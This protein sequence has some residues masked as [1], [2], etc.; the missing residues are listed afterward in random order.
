MIALNCESTVGDCYSIAPTAAVLLRP[1]FPGL[2]NGLLLWK[3]SKQYHTW[4]RFASAS[5][6]KLNSLDRAAN[7]FTVCE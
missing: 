4:R 7:N 3:H 2:F 5:R 6:N 1:D